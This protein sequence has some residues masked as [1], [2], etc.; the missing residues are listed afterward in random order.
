MNLRSAMPEL[1]AIAPF[2][3]SI[4]HYFTPEAKA[5]V[6]AAESVKLAVVGRRGATTPTHI[7]VA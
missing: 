6:A 2:L 1:T 5:A 7:L 3:L 4:G